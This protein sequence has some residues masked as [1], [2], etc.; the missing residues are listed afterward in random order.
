[1]I[2]FDSNTD[3]NVTMYRIILP[4]FC[5]LFS[6]SSGY[7]LDKE[8]HALLPDLYNHIYEKVYGEKADPMMQQVTRNNAYACKVITMGY[9]LDSVIVADYCDSLRGKI[10]GFF[11]LEENVTLHEFSKYD[12][13]DL[14]SFHMLC[15]ESE[16]FSNESVTLSSGNNVTVSVP[17]YT[18]QSTVYRLAFAKQNHTR[19]VKHISRLTLHISTINRLLQF[20]NG[21]SPASFDALKSMYLSS[22]PLFEIR[23]QDLAIFPNLETLVLV[24]MPIVNEALENG[25]FCNNSQLKGFSFYSSI[26]NLRLFPKQIFNCSHPLAL[27]LLFLI[28]HQIAHLPKNAFMSAAKH[29]KMIA[30]NNVCLTSIHKDAFYEVYSLETLSL[31]DTCLLET[32]QIQLPPSMQLEF[33]L[34][35]NMLI[36]GAVNLDNYNIIN[37]TELIMFHWRNTYNSLIQSHFCSKDVPSKLQVI[38]LRN[39]ELTVLPADLFQYCQSLSLLFL[40][41]NK[42]E[43]LDSGLFSRD[44]SN[45]KALTVAYNDLTDNTSWS[46]VLQ[47]QTQLQYLN[48]SGNILTSWT[49]PL[50]NV[51][52]LRVLDLSDN[53][54]SSISSAAFFNKTKLQFLMLSINAITELDLLPSSIGRGLAWNFTAQDTQLKSLVLVDISINLLASIFVSPKQQ[55]PNSCRDISIKIPDNS[56]TSFK[57]DC[58]DK[59]NYGLIDLSINNL[60]DFFDLFPLALHSV[61]IVNTLNVSHNPLDPNLNL[62]P[63]LR[64]KECADPHHVDLLDLSNCG[65]LSISMT[66]FIIFDIK[67]LDLSR[68]NLI[69]VFPGKFSGNSLSMNLLDNPLMCDCHLLWLKQEMMNQSNAI[70]AKNCTSPFYTAPKQIVTVHDKIFLCPTGC[71]N[72]VKLECYTSTC[73]TNRSL[74]GA[75]KAVTCYAEPNKTQILA[76]FSQVENYLGLAGFHLRVLSLPY[77][78]KSGIVFLNLAANHIEI[79]PE[80][81]FSMVPLLVNLMLA[82]NDITHLP[83]SVF[84]SLVHL[85]YL[86]LA[87][88]NL[89]QWS[90]ELLASN[91]HLL[92]LFLHS[93]Q[94]R[95]LSNEVLYELERVQEVSL[96]DNPWDCYCNSSFQSWIVNNKEELMLPEEIR[97]NGSGT[98]VM[99]TNVP[100]EKQVEV[101]IVDDRAHR[102][103]IPLTSSLAALSLTALVIC[104]VSYRYRFLLTVVVYTYLPHWPWKKASNAGTAGRR[105]IGVFA[106]YDDQERDAYMWVKDH[107]IPHIELEGEEAEEQEGCRLICYD[108]DFVP[109]MDMIDN[110][111]AAIKATHCCVMLLTNKF[112]DNHWSRAMFQAVFCEVLERKRPYKLISVLWSGVTIKDVSSHN[113][114]PTDLINLLKSNRVLNVDGKL[115]WQSLAYLIRKHQSQNESTAPGE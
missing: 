106:I 9:D 2:I 100:C 18:C 67:F 12:V 13:S 29:L 80:G 31:E 97:C 88:N 108:R 98:P 16:G 69:H 7:D 35:D 74:V 104:L 83:A 89:N 50:R 109:G 19:V 87:N 20:I 78:T 68:N 1:M 39:D 105:R 107:L 36:D 28:D 101:F 70:Q 61:C 77:M 110:I 90:P 86:D 52:E 51:G 27:E 92:S 14:K 47:D 66:S 48:L 34:I 113:F 25:L 102:L 95:N 53:F 99:L 8:V 59:Q 45:L 73:F 65:L 24:R 84:N 3:S 57:L 54:I 55:C 72:Y 93:N 91:R 41:F 63:E 22:M 79:I 58:T 46:R 15:E 21:T 26:N 111:E 33:I 42:L 6:V 60:T 75:I 4:L 17:R 71:P 37:R 115:F 32:A 103:I 76:E 64:C 11:G 38:D 5:A 94:L 30:M 40:D 62:P 85:E 114:C 56:L 49:Q 81:S 43:S 44:V 112:L 10:D 23:R 96:V 82:H